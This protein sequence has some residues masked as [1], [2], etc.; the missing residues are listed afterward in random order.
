MHQR[1]KL[2]TARGTLAARSLLAVFFCLTLSSVARAPRPTEVRVEAAPTALKCGEG[3]LALVRA[4]MPADRNVTTKAHANALGVAIVPP[5]ASGA[6]KFFGRYWFRMESDGGEGKYFEKRDDDS[7]TIQKSLSTFQ[8]KELPVRF[9]KFF[10]DCGLDAT[11][12]D[13]FAKVLND[14]TTNVSLDDLA[15]DFEIN[16]LPLALET[17]KSAPR[18]L[19]AVRDFDDATQLH[20]AQT[21]HDLLGVMFGGHGPLNGGETNNDELQAAI[22]ARDEALAA[23]DAAERELA[24]ARS[25]RDVA[26][27]AS[28]LSLYL[29]YLFWTLAATLTLFVLTGVVLALRPQWRD[30]LRLLF[31]REGRTQTTAPPPTQESPAEGSNADGAGAAA[32]GK[33]EALEQK[34]QESL[35]GMVRPDSNVL[36]R[37]EMARKKVE[38]IWTRVGHGPCPDEALKKIDEQLSEYTKLLEPLRRFCPEQSP[39]D[40]LLYMREAVGIFEDL[41]QRFQLKPTTP[42][43]IRSKAGTFFTDLFNTHAEFF[44]GTSDAANTPDGMLTAL[45]CKLGDGRTAEE[46]LKT[47]DK[48]LDGLRRELKL[49][50]SQNDSV[51]LAKNIFREYRAALDTLSSHAQGHNGNLV[52]ASKW[53]A[54]Q[55]SSSKKVIELSVDDASASLDLMVSDLLRQYQGNKEVAAR[56][57]EI[58]ER[59]DRVQEELT[60]AL[61][62]TSAFSEVASTLSRLLYLSAG[63]ELSYEDVAAIS[64][65]LADA[66]FVHRQLRLRLSA[67]VSALDSVTEHLRAGGRGDAL[68]AL[69]VDKFR[70]ELLSLLDRMEDFRGDELWSR[71][72]FQGFST[73]ELSLLL[74]AEMLATTYFTDDSLLSRLIDPLH[75]ASEA[76]RAAVSACGVVLRPVKLL[77]ELPR[78]VQ[79]EGRVDPALR[80]LREVRDKVVRAINDKRETFVVDVEAFPYDAGG[81]NRSDGLVIKVI[82]A[83]WV[84]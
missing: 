78:G 35:D 52:A 41:S 59:A 44:P 31:I 71:C 63:E 83:E 43:E 6:V 65:R 16:K 47:L 18:D 66:E 45:L 33:F 9:G 3:R 14:S 7:G 8:T 12:P 76:L 81:A 64:R 38:Q 75:Q 13:V 57:R 82:P 27:A 54:D 69:R 34:V 26:L 10:T 72:L 25:A 74:R 58:E 24:A 73:Q 46:G 42:G 23:H 77:S 61:A 56:A 60:Q 79:V 36:F 32:K 48:S 39:Q 29:K 30:R 49:E 1:H 84:Y 80:A 51:E 67:A 21:L 20:F 17:A 70:P 19:G 28:R 55:I 53:V 15:R 5:D 37:L 4:E 68:E 50:E 2:R 22:K 11:A 62:R 40:T